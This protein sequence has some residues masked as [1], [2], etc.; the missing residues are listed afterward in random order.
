MTTTPAPQTRPSV[1]APPEDVLLEVNNLKMYFPVTSGIIFQKK[2]AD[3]KAV[4]D[5][6]FSVRRG[7]TLGLVGE[8]GCGKTTTIQTVIRAHEP[9]DGG[10][11]YHNGERGHRPLRPFRKRPHRPSP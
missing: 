5:I 8:S 3:I 9:T 4:D 2:V 6:S 7:E 11:I 10:V 1:P